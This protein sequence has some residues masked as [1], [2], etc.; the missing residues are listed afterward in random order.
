VFAKVECKIICKPYHLLYVTS[1]LTWRIPFNVTV[2]GFYFLL[3]IYSIKCSCHIPLS[4]SLSLS[5]SL[6]CFYNVE[7]H[8]KA[9]SNDQRVYLPSNKLMILM[10]P[11]FICNCHP[12][13]D[14]SIL[15]FTTR[16]LAPNIIIIHANKTSVSVD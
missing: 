2:I 4:L 1:L 10:L 3:T 6:L 9:S 12:S 11:P 16:N 15:Q 7:P 5:L 14:Q 13:E 8:L